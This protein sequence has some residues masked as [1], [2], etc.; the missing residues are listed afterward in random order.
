MKIIICGATG[1]IGSHLVK[2]F[3]NG[4]NDIF[5]IFNKRSPLKDTSNKVNWFKAD[6]RTPDSLKSSH[7]GTDLFYNLQLQ[8]QAQRHH[9]K[10]L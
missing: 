2:H 5:A 6:L 10:A 1:F 8:H 9:T 4:E 3:D 7:K